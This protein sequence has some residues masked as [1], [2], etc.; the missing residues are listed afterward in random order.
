M[1]LLF[2]LQEAGQVICVE[3]IFEVAVGEHEEVQIPA[4][5]HH[6]VEGTELLEAQRP[7]VVICICLLQ[8]GQSFFFHFEELQMF[9]QA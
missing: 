6:L 5:R 1:Y 7:L 9:L 3:V 2:S 4:G 8:Q